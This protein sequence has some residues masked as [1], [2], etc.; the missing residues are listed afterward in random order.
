MGAE[1]KRKVLRTR[2]A[3]S[4]PP[5]EFSQ[6]SRDGLSQSDAAIHFAILANP[7]ADE[8]FDSVLRELED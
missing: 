2:K 7:E 3:P 5:R 4:L 6:P 1:E 8:V